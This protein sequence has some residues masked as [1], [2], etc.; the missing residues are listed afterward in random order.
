MTT[1]LEAPTGQRVTPTGIRVL[2]ASAPRTDWLEAR[3]TGI[4]A[5]DI[6]KIVGSSKYGSAVDVYADKNGQPLLDD[7]LGEAGQWGMELEDYVARRWAEINGVRIRRIGLLRNTTD[8]MMLASLDRLVLD[9][10]HASPDQPDTRCALEVKTRNA[11][12][13]DEWTDGVPDSVN[14]QVQWQLDVSGLDHIHVAALIGGQRLVE[15]VVHPDEAVQS[16]LRVKAHETWFCVTAGQP[17]VVDPALMSVDLLNRVY[18]QREGTRVVDGNL[19]RQLL[20]EY[21]ES[22]AGEKAFKDTKERIKVELLTLLGVGEEA[23]D[24]HAVTLFTYKAQSSRKVDYKL[25]ETE[26][27]DVYDEVVTA[28]TSRTFRPSK[29][30]TA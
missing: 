15:H 28:S 10:T 25:L 5:T 9:C 26:H 2:P 24:E 29:A 17:P 20:T 27:P 11:Y 14:V 23:V 16:W 7:E 3:R 21:A 1:T 6:V 30:A 22:T 13:L 4:T 18:Q 19:T 8:P 12:V